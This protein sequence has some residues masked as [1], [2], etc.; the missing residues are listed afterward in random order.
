EIKIAENKRHILETKEVH[1]VD[2]QVQIIVNSFNAIVSDLQ[3]LCRHHE[4]QEMLDVGGAFHRKSLAQEFLTFSDASKNYDQIRFLDETGMEI[5]RINFNDGEP[6]IVPKHQLQSKGGRYYFADTFRLNKGEVFVSPFDLNIEK[7]KIEIPIKPVI[8]FGTPI[9]DIK[10]QKRGIVIINYLG[11]KLIDRLKSASIGAPGRIM[12]LNAGGYWLHGMGPEDEWGFMYED[13]K[14]VTFANTYPDVWH[15]ISVNKSGHFYNSNGLFTFATVFPLMEGWKT[16][17]GSGNAFE[18]GKMQLKAE[19]HKW[20]IVSHVMPEDLEIQSYILNY[21]YQIYGSFIVIIGFISWILANASVNKKTRQTQVKRSLREVEIVN[22]ELKREVDERKKAVKA[23]SESEEIFR[24]IGTSA[25]D[26]IIMIDN[27]SI[28]SFWNH[29]AEEIFGYSREDAV[30]KQLKNLIIPEKLRKA[31]LNGFEKFKETGQGPVIGKTVELSA[32]RKDGAEFPISLSLSSVKIKDKWNAIGILRD[33][34]DRKRIETLMEKTLEER[35]KSI[36]EIKQ[37]MEFSSLMR[38][39]TSENELIKHM[40]QALRKNFQPDLLAVLMLN[41]KERIIEVSF[42]EPQMPTDKLIKE[43]A[44]LD[45]SLC[46]VLSTGQKFIVRDLIKD[47][48][49]DC[50][51]HSHKIEDGGYACLPIIAGGGTVGMVLLSRKEKDYWADEE[52]EKLLSTY[53]GI[54]ASALHNMRLTNLTKTEAVTDVLTGAYNRRFFD[55]VMKRQLSLANRYKRFLGLL[56]ADIDHF[57]DFNDKYGHEAGDQI[58][59]H[60]AKILK[61]S[62]RCSDTLARYGGEEFA[63]IIPATVKTNVLKKADQIRMVVEFTNFD[64]IVLGQ[65]LKLTISI[66]VASFPEHG[67]EGDTLIAAADKA[68]YKAK[69]NGR[70]KVEIF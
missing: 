48:F 46:R 37:L 23:L 43:E 29:A 64:N 30:G 39:E 41:R 51:I 54:A 2:Q 28:I 44:I 69:E 3:I 57:K 24:A 63:I 40:V 35:N 20:K 25:K 33:I 19:E 60:V 17:T 58:L 15:E 55:E 49:C 68:L 10:V 14:N 4:M 56:I 31:H 16:T 9:V 42:I 52:R 66:G 5:I 32:I 18:K 34:T 36:K 6:Y 26:A 53:V 8:R 59:Q 11:Y 12:L 27:E 47:P 65:S 1:Y 67:T 62:I 61:N 38:D 13:R 21:F 70:N 45:P 7:G 22:E 50:I